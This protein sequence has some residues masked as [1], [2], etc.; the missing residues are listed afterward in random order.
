MVLIAVPTAVVVLVDIVRNQV[1][2]AV[3]HIDA[4]HV[5]GSGVVT[6]VVVKRRANENDIVLNGRVFVGKKICLCGVERA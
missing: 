5:D 3:E 4:K 2:I 1:A 6:V